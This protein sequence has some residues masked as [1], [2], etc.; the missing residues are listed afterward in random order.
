MGEFEIILNANTALKNT[1][2]FILPRI[3]DK[4]ISGYLK[5]KCTINEEQIKFSFTNVKFTFTTV[6]EYLK[7]GLPHIAE[8]RI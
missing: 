2:N 1:L 5:C 6:K 4:R 7:F 3:T 8:K